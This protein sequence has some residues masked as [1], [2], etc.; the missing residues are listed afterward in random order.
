M[1]C[2][3]RTCAQIDEA[4]RRCALGRHEP[5]GG[6]LE[7]KLSSRLQTLFVVENFDCC[8]R[9]AAG[10]WQALAIVESKMAAAAPFARAAFGNHRTTQTVCNTPSKR[11]AQ[12][13]SRRSTDKFGRRSTAACARLR[14]RAQLVAAIRA[15][16]GATRFVALLLHLR[17]RSGRR[18]RGARL[19]RH[20]RQ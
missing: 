20:H 2:C 14:G 6:Q 11:W 18:A 16:S 3:A 12:N 10:Y 15:A 1:S 13:A 17:F 8:E 9:R 19:P 4:A 5:H 7:A